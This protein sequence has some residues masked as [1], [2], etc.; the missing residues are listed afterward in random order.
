MISGQFGIAMFG[1]ELILQLARLLLPS[2]LLL[3][4]LVS[5]ILGRTR[6]T[7]HEL[8]SPPSKLL[9]ALAPPA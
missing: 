3:L 4:F 1:A 2:G 8:P 7:S 5:H 9:N 6:K